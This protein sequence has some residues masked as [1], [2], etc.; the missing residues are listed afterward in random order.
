MVKSKLPR[1]RTA[2]EFEALSDED[3]E[4][5]YQYFD[6]MSSEEL[7]AKSKPLN[8]RERARWRKLIGKGRKLKAK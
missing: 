8:A 7:R 4:R 1:F 2:S 6:R 3:K 5:V